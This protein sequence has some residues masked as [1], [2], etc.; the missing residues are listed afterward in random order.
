M[1]LKRIENLGLEIKAGRKRVIGEG[2]S[3][4]FYDYDNHLFELHTGIFGNKTSSLPKRTNRLNLI[5]TNQKY[6]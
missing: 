1:Y 5:V 4:Y 6:C 2:N 3:I